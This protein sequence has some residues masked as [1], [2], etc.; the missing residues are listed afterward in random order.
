MERET[1]DFEAAWERIKAV[2]GARTQVEIA[3]LLDIRQSSISD[4]K[5]RQT[6]PD[7]WLVALLA[8][9]G[10]N[11]EWI[12]TGQGAIYLTADTA[13]DIPD[14]VRRLAVAVPEPEPTPEPTVSELKAALEAKLGDG[15][16]LYFAGDDDVVTFSHREPV[17][18]MAMDLDCR[19]E[20]AA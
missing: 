12:K 17:T 16:H 11:P 20:Q 8:L 13:R 15:L 4:A 19:P 2:S 18:P 10:V 6:V 14:G 9:Y 5:R 3:K 7:T 1:V